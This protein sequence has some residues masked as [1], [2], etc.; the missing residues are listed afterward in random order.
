MLV[1]ASSRRPASTHV[2]V[3]GNEKGGAGKSTIAMHVAVALLNFGQRVA[4]IDL[5]LRQRSFTCYI[6]NRRAW[7]KRSGCI[8]ALP[9]H[10]CVPRGTTQKLDDNETIE[11][12]GFVDALTSV[13]QTHDFI[14]IDTAGT[15][16]HLTRLAHSMANTLITP[17][18]DSFVDFNVL[19]T[20]DPE[21]YSVTGESHYAR[22]VRESRQQ[23]RLA[24]GAQ[25][26]W[27][28]V[29][30]RVSSLESRNK[31]R[32]AKG[33]GELA[34][35]LG[36]R[37]AGPLGDRVIYRELFPRGI[38]ALDALDEKTL[39]TRPTLSHVTARRE[40]MS[41]IEMLK[42]PI[43][44]RARERAAAHAEWQAVRDKPLDVHD[45]IEG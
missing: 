23:R 43:D 2:V 15:D 20:V 31:Q 3:L 19:G 32:I 26:D 4:T 29:R 18:N 24:D 27:L 42:L 40:L 37:I 8:L 11:F 34:V 22:M 35:R 25:M 21:S 6:E 9:D 45:V 30:N 39:G 41:L 1:Q 36:F 44:E 28:V 17:L 10:H 38:T 5:D 7:A 16:S 13:E 33:I 14:V 12:A